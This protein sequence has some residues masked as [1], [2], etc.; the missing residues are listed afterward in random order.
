MNEE[1]DNKDGIACSPGIMLVAYGIYYLI[2]LSKIKATEL[3]IILNWLVIY[4]HLYA[5]SLLSVLECPK[6]CEKLDCLFIHE[7]IAYLFH[8]YM[9]KVYIK[10]A[11]LRLELRKVSTSYK[12][13]S[14]NDV[15]LF[16]LRWELL[17]I[18]F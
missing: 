16:L 9:Y 7:S 12:L 5:L 17:F 14:S 1:S 11:S 13:A 15:E 4:R 2:L 10:S 18:F 6:I 3:I 8:I